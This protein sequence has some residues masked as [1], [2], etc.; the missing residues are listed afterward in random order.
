[1]TMRRHELEVRATPAASLAA[2]EDAA[3]IWGGA[4]HRL[5]TGGA[6]ELPVSAGL[7]LGVLHGQ[8]STE[9][10]RDG[11]LLVYHVQE[12]RYRL[13]VAHFVVLLLGGLGG[14]TLVLAPFFPRFLGI[15]PLAG[16]LLLLA[17]FLVAAR[18]HSSGADEFLDLVRSMAEGG[19]GEEGEGPA[20]EGA[21]DD[22]PAPSA[23][24]G[25]LE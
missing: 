25:A 2:V 13:R 14:A 12:S 21:N 16:L 22:R 23:G 17:W 1:M 7:R 24:I 4:W 19:E 10:A 5:G 8:V 18:L 9:G 3:S 11:T 6:L 20:P 15:T